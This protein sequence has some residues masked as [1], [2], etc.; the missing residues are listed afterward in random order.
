MWS[1]KNRIISLALIVAVVF[2]ICS[3]TS[4][5]EG[6][7][8]I[9]IR[10]TCYTATEGSITA[11]GSEVYEGIASGKREWIGKIA[12][13]YDLDMNFI[14]FFEFKDTGSGIDTDG[15]GIGDSIKNGKSIDVY[16]NTLGECHE[17]VDQYGDYVLM[18]I[19]DAEG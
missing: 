17:W 10:C 13:L 6:N 11:S 1:L 3:I 12:I 15:D 2:A 7:D 18:Q 5:A 14:G 16:R 19:V 4:N 8:L 9:K